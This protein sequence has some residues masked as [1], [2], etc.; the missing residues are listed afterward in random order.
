MEIF[1]FPTRVLLRVNQGSGFSNSS[2]RYSDSNSIDPGRYEVRSGSRSAK[3][4][5]ELD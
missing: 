2:D 4:R 1:K 3:I 5:H